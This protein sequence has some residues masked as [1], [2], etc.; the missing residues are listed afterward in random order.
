MSNAQSGLLK[1]T[2]VRAPAAGAGPIG[3]QSW[4]P[5]R[6]MDRPASAPPVP[7]TS[8]NFDAPASAG[9][10]AVS[11][12]AKRTSLFMAATI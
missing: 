6:V 7:F 2:A 12:I 11:K 1:S 9:A 3:F 4:V 5:E 8:V 10:P